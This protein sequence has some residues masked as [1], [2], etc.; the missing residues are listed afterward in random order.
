[1]TG[2]IITLFP[3]KGYGFIRGTDGLT[4]FMHAKEVVPR[5]AFDTMHEGL[6]VEFE[7][8]EVGPADEGNRLRALRVTRAK[9][10]S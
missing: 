10:D 9:S 5:L 1:M 7:P 2:P 6:L 8:A 4:Y 3:N